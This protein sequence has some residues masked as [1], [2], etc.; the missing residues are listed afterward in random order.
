MCDVARMDDI[1]QRIR[2]NAFHLWEQAGCPEGRAEEFWARAEAVER[3][4]GE[5][6]P[7]ETDKDQDPAKFA[8]F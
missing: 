4:L 5:T 2:E 6:Q 3:G 7:A 8:G 1:E